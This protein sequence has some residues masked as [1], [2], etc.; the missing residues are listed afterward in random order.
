MMRQGSE[1]NST[2]TSETPDFSLVLGGPLF[3]LFRKARLHGDAL[4]LLHR[5]ILVITIIAWVPL[6]SVGVRESCRRGQQIPSADI[7]APVH[8]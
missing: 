1:M 3:Q 7:E 5:R 6:R 4:E 2:P 8:F